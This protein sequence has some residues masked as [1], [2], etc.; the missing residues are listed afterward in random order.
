MTST[1]PPLRSIRK[2]SFPPSPTPSPA[3][4]IADAWQRET[5]ENQEKW[6][7]INAAVGTRYATP[8]RNVPKPKM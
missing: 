3:Q 2:Q 8:A 7:R 5:S 6:K 1:S 4:A